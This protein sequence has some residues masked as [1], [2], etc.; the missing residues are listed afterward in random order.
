MAI[1]WTIENGSAVAPSRL[2]V[3]MRRHA[4]VLTGAPDP[5]V[6]AAGRLAGETWEYRAD[7]EVAP[8][9][10]FGLAVELGAG[11]HVGRCDV[12]SDNEVDDDGTAADDVIYAEVTAHRTRLSVV[13]G[14]AAGLALLELS[15]GEISGA[16]LA[17]RYGHA[18][19]AALLADLQVPATTAAFP[20]SVDALAI[21]LGSANL[22]FA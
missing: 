17:R 20:A 7:D 6:S 21:R 10:E 2:V 12:S 14:L 19:L 11:A 4:L 15:G 3:A 5:V 22:P 16:G 1:S 8:V 9:T 13:S 18:E